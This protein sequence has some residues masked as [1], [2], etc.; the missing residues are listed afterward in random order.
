MRTTL[1]WAFAGALVLLACQPSEARTGDHEQAFAEARSYHDYVA[2]G[3]SFT[4]GAGIRPVADASCFRSVRNYP[5]QL[6]DRLGARLH[7]DS[8]GGATAANA[9]QPQPMVG[10]TNPPQLSAVNRRTDLVTISLGLNDTGY[11]ALLTRCPQVALLNP[12]GSPCRASFQTPQGDTILS[13]VTAFG[14]DL[15]RVIRLVQN[16]APRADVVVVGVPQLAPANGTCPDLPFAAG[17]YGYLAEYLVDL[18]DVMEQAA[19]ET[20]ARFVDVLS[21]SKGH[22]I[23]AGD[24]AW[25]LGSVASTRTMSWHPFA[26]EQRAV[27][28]L[29]ERDLR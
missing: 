15:E 14:A 2:I 1:T 26:N 7:D 23:C 9:E 22:D 6:A 8:C 17:D 28:G 24:D 4:S 21:A 13:G 19:D 5:N 27:A 3:D 10:E 20:D 16:A 25:V 29:I 18:N 11:G 12:Q